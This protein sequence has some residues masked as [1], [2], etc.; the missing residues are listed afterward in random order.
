MFP[1]QSRRA[2]L[3][4]GWVAVTIGVTGCSQL[5]GNSPDSKESPTNDPSKI[6]CKVTEFPQPTPTKE[7]LRPKEYPEYPNELSED[8][9]ARFAEQFE[10]A[11]QYNQFLT[12]LFPEGTDELHIIGGVPEWGI[13]EHE[14]GYL[15][16][17]QG[18]VKSADTHHPA[19]ST[20]TAAPSGTRP[21]GTWYQCTTTQALRLN[22]G[23]GIQKS[24]EPNMDVATVICE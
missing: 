12:D 19:N 24:E 15:V 21:F 7:G 9:T 23:D 6:E 13:R 3:H 2:F 17:V 11:Y 20:K 1:K 14:S 22:D 8:S 5:T 18:Q 16:G 4:S 10:E